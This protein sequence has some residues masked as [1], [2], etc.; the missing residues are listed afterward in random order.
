MTDLKYGII[1]FLILLLTAVYLIWLYRKGETEK[2][3]SRLKSILAIVVILVISKYVMD[4]FL[5]M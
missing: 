5:L 3:K 4:Y 1:L 2:V